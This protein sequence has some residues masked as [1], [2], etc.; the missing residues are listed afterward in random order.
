MAH[1][2]YCKK[3]FSTLY[4]LLNHQKT[5]KACISIQKENGVELKDKIFLSVLFVKGN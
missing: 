1:C 3:T 2:E 5:T 4:S